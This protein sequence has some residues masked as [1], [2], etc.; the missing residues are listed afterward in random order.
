MSNNFAENKFYNNAL[1]SNH[2]LFPTK[3][4]LD[5]YRNICLFKTCI[6]TPITSLTILN[7]KCSRIVSC[8]TIPISI[9]HT[10]FQ[11]KNLHRLTE[12]NRLKKGCDKHHW[13]DR[14]SSFTGL[15]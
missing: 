12:Q 11:S 9:S 14:L 7:E 13:K 15:A 10:L 3:K 6:E 1:L 8:E 2:I 4:H 5:I